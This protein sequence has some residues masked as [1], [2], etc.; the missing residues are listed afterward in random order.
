[1]IRLE[2]LTEGIKKRGGGGTK[3]FCVCLYECFTQHE[4]SSVKVF[5]LEELQARSVDGTHSLSCSTNF[6]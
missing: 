6:F 3:H 1:M 2:R 4:R 5:Y